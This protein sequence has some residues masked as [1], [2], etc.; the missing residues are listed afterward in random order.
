MAGM[1]VVLLVV[2]LRPTFKHH[3]PYGVGP[4]FP[5]YLW[6]TRVGAAGG[7]SL[8]GVRPGTPSLLAALT[9]SLHLPL[10]A[11]VAGAQ[12]A[13]VPAIGFAA[14]ALVRRGLTAGRWKWILTGSLAGLFAVHLA[15]GYLSNLIFATAFVGAAAALAA[16]SRRATVAAALMLGG[17]GLAH[18]QFFAL[19]A[20]IMA[21]AALWSF[22]RTHEAGAGSDF[23]RVAAVLAGG[24]AIVAAGLLL[25]MLGAPALRVDTS[26]DA[27]LRRAGMKDLLVK[28]YKERFDQKAHLYAPIPLIGLAYP[29]YTRTSGFTRRFL[30]SWA[31]VSLVGVPIGLVTGLF[32]PERILTFGFAFPILAA[33]G[34]VW[35]HERLGGRRLPALLVAAAL[36]SW[37]AY[38]WIGAWGQEQTFMS[39]QE[40]TDLNIAARIASTLPAGTHLV[41][42]VNDID[43]TAIFLA[44]H[45][46]NVIRATLPPDRVADAYV[47]VGDSAQL[48]K[49]L[50]TVRGHV[51]Y[52]TLSRVLLSQIPPGPEAI[53]VIQDLNRVPAALT[54]PT[55]F[56][57]T[58][59]VTS[60][61]PDPRPLPPLAGELTPSSP[62][63]IAV[64]SA[65][66]F[67]LLLIAGLGWSVWAF[68]PTLEAVAA[69]P[70]LGVA[71]LALIGLVFERAGMPVTGSIGPTLIVMA[72]TG[73]GFGLRSWAQRRPSAASDRTS[74]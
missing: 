22:A 33:L 74:A 67:A 43:L 28:T 61:V 18:P 5:V 42:V 29:G 60:S 8:V 24:A 38:V 53:F 45:A 15:A 3:W 55:L 48:R 57:W 68:G 25:T 2:L 7:M 64:A 54:D 20:L 35:I 19:G 40:V 36:I 9:G 27:F 10:V 21:G 32:P 73:G 37:M 46:E 26:K 72:T 65:S 6:W 23:R 31:A 4:D 14:I 56:R 63:Q 13:L 16:R 62:V 51:Q 41:Y 34:V 59:A 66:I 12:Y 71:M 30:F 69:A 58:P 50:P 70:A 44:T 52:D 39:P 17:G 47:Y 11:V 1:V 49:G